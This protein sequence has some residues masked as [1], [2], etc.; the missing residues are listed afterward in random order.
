[1]KGGVMYV[2]RCLSL[3]SLSRRVV[4]VLSYIFWVCIPV[5]RLDAIIMVGSLTL[6]TSPT[7]PVLPGW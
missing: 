1:M 6:M 7:C 2:T 5:I 4:T 3:L